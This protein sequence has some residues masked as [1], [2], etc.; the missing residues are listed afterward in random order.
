MTFPPTG[1]APVPLLVVTAHGPS[2]PRLRVAGE[3][4]IAT[5]PQLLDAVAA[6]AGRSPVAGD[7]VHLDLADVSFL[8]AA[9]LD[10][11]VAAQDLVRAGG[12]RLRVTGVRPLALVLLEVTGLVSVLEVERS[13]ALRLV[14][15][16]PRGEAR[17]AAVARRQ[18]DLGIL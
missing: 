8:D 2:G 1:D 3:L 9:G 16:A 5:A 12:R 11:L 18:R 14:P 7:V 17:E 15:R 6:T 4:D 13:P 10:A